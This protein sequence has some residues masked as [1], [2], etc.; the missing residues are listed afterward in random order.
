MPRQRANCVR[1]VAALPKPQRP[2]TCSTDRLCS[3][4]R[5]ACPLRR[6]RRLDELRL[7]AVAV[8][9]HDHPPR[10]GIGDRSA[11]LLAHEVL[12]VGSALGLR[13]GADSR[14]GRD[15][16]PHCLRGQRRPG[17]AGPPDLG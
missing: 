8:R 16:Q 14:D 3:S 11:V 12:V 7:A 17:P 5:C 6:H 1:S 4:N 2:A 10:D 13:W 15:W 9:R